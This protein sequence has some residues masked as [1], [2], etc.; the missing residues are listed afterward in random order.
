MF[1]Y[2]I[3]L[4]N[5]YSNIQSVSYSKMALTLFK[6]TL[7]TT[8]DRIKIKIRLDYLIDNQ[9]LISDKTITVD[10]IIN[11][12]INAFTVNRVA[13]NNP[14]CQTCITLKSYT[15]IPN[16]NMTLTKLIRFIEYGNED[17]PAYPWIQRA[18]NKTQEKLTLSKSSLLKTNM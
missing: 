6:K 12:I 8:V 2:Y 14:L 1:Q 17:I 4:P 11:L 10:Y 18:W 13:T 5:N 15:L 16:T 7:N 9:I 3:T